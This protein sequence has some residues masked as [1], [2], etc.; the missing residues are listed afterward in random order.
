MNMQIN[1]NNTGISRSPTPST[2]NDVPAE[3]LQTQRELS[4]FIGLEAQAD[5]RRGLALG[6][7]LTEN[8][9]R[10][11]STREEAGTNNILRHSTSSLAS[12]QEAIEQALRNI[13]SSNLSDEQKRQLTRALMDR[14]GTICNQNVNISGAMHE[15]A[16]LYE[17]MSG[18]A[19]IFNRGDRNAELRRIRNN[20]H[21]LIN[22]GFRDRND[23][24]DVLDGILSG[25]NS[26]NSRRVNTAMN[27]LGGPGFTVRSQGMAAND[28]SAISASNNSASNQIT[29]AD[30]TIATIRVAQEGLAIAGGATTFAMGL[31]YSTGYR[32]IHALQNGTEALAN[33]AY[34]TNEGAEAAGRRAAAHGAGFLTD[35]LPGPLGS[36]AQNV[37]EQMIVD[38]QSINEVDFRAAAT[39][40]VSNLAGSMGTRGITRALGRGA[41]TNLTRVIAG[42]GGNVIGDQV[43]SIIG[44]PGSSS[45]PPPA[46]TTTPTLPTVATA[47]PTPSVSTVT[48]G[49]PA[50]PIP[51][52]PVAGG[53]SHVPSA[54][55]IYAGN[56]APQAPTPAPITQQ[57]PLIAMTMEV[58]YGTDGRPYDSLGGPLNQVSQTLPWITTPPSVESQQQNFRDQLGI[59]LMR[60]A[61][62]IPNPF[63]RMFM[64][65]TMLAQMG[66]INMNNNPNQN[67]PAYLA[68]QRLSRLNNQN[69]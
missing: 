28:R 19:N 4:N 47:P 33:L 63:I 20:T 31:G 14:V 40:G 5:R 25:L 45:P 3:L 24:L 29:V 48:A 15:T 50:T 69:V 56:P 34:G 66:L 49:P 55:T 57:Q 67:S 60:R 21:N 37:A 39:D 16:G 62:S 59:N 68:Y 1:T 58:R 42:A 7:I 23:Q 27:Q 53:Y 65:I 54:E 32:G 6:R 13:Q 64:M 8:Q 10:N 35:R 11:S 36:S 9:R 22:N 18:S 51:P 2:N 30:R 38:G 41:P 46:P 61:S 43:S 12:R 52:A 26:G 17:G 44:R